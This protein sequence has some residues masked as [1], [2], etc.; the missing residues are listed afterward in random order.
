M[1]L[2]LLCVTII[3]ASA[4][5]I[6][7]GEPIPWDGFT[8]YPLLGDDIPMPYSIVAA[9]RA[10]S[11]GAAFITEAGVA[12]PNKSSRITPEKSSEEALLATMNLLQSH[13]IS[14]FYLLLICGEL[15]TGGMQDRIIA[16]D[17]VIPPGASQMDTPA[18][19]VELDRWFPNGQNPQVNGVI[20]DPQ[21]RMQA[22]INPLQSHIW[23]L[24]NDILKETKV[25][26][27]TRTYNSLYSAILEEQEVWDKV[28][29]VQEILR[30]PKIRGL[31][32]ANGDHF[33]A[34]DLFSSHDLLVTYW[35]KLL[36]AYQ[37]GAKRLVKRPGGFRPAEAQA[38]LDAM[39]SAVKRGIALENY[40]PDCD[41]QKLIYED[42]YVGVDFT[43]RNN[44]IHTVFFN[45]EP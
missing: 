2:L 35:P 24:I 37:L 20:I 4:A 10:L 28:E 41:Y 11:V 38:V 31:L 42:K 36:L 32:I 30:D 29:A 1:G 27:I 19:C 13:N 44:S 3:P 14:R 12:P 9:D 5:N 15:S 22:L 16:Q 39:Q 25:K 21:L 33:W 18:F 45:R 26:T 43:Y 6:T 40:P 17:V 8:I 34:L 23:Q 7:L